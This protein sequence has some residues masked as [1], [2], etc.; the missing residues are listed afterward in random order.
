MA[1]LGK[2]FVT[3][4][5]KFDAKGFQK[6]NESIR[7]VSTAITAIGGGMVAAGLKFTQYASNLEETT[8]KFNVVFE[9]Q[10]KIAEEWADTLVK[11]YGTSTEEAKRFLGSIQDLLVPMGMQ[12]ESAAKLS[13]EIVKLTVDL[14]SFNNLPTEQ[15]MLDVQSALVGNFETMK[16]YG[17]VLNATRVEQEIMN[18]GWVTSKD[19][20]TAAMKAQ[21]AYNLIVD[22]SEAALGDFNR[23]SEGYANQVKIMRARIINLQAAIGEKLLPAMKDVVTFISDKVVPIIG[24]IVDKMKVISIE[25]VALVG[26]ITALSIALTA[27]SI[28]VIPGLI[29]MI[30]GAKIAIT[31]LFT[32]IA[33]HPI[34][35]LAV[36]VGAVSLGLGKL[37]EKFIDTRS[38]AIETGNTIESLIEIQKKRLEATKMHLANVKLSQEERKRA[39]EEFLWLINDIRRLES[40]LEQQRITEKQDIATQE[41]EINKSTLDDFLINSDRIIK[42]KQDL[43]KR[44]LKHIENLEKQRAEGF[45][46]FSDGLASSWSGAMSKFIIEGGKASTALSNIW[47]GIRDHIVN[48]I[49]Q[50]IAKWITFQVLTGGAGLLRI[51]I[52]GFQHGIRNFRGG[53]AVVGERGPELVNLPRGSDVIPNRGGGAVSS[54]RNVTINN[55]LS[56]AN[57]TGDNID[58]VMMKITEA[59]REGMIEADNMIKAIR[60]KSAIIGAEG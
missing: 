2:F 25:I 5:S 36:G 11:S 22:G 23:T 20:I 58:D 19:D 34:G 37:V 53:M 1:E 49:S 56:G 15:V 42:S 3:I 52:P 26:G 44:A 40:E 54:T 14:G 50:M 12:K 13:N 31:G 33:A 38:E 46:R 9:G 43:Y 35:A 47:K 41:K 48:M 45:K 17:V 21:A 27:L 55:D 59:T 29:S 16:K 8:S 4:G 7:K 24:D 28:T 39:E 18:E 51:P 32:L 60:D 30:G 57:I 6:A 10:Q